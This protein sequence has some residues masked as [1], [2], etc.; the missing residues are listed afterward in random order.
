MLLNKSR[1]ESKLSSMRGVRRHFDVMCDVGI[2]QNETRMRCLKTFFIFFSAWFSHFLQSFNVLD[3]NIIAKNPVFVN[4]VWFIENR[5]QQRK[6]SAKDLVSRTE[7]KSESLGTR[8]NDLLVVVDT[9]VFELQINEWRWG[10][11]LQLW[12]FFISST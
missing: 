7:K 3:S 5:L 1:R 6:R 9:W 12:T 4:C 8:L 11:L 10:W 2:Y